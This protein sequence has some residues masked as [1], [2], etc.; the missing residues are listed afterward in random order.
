MSTST[1]NT[2]IQS[3]LDTLSD[4]LTTNLPL[5]LQIAAGLVALGIVIRYIKRWVGRK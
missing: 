2:M 5:V 4:S 3:F 1:I